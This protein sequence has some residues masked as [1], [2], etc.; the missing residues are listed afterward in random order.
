[1][2][3]AEKTAYM[4]VVS[5]F[6]VE[7]VLPTIKYINKGCSFET[8]ISIAVIKSVVYNVRKTKAFLEK[9]FPED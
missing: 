3:F 9:I 1:L 7:I 6:I 5:K 8:A 2:D 4:V